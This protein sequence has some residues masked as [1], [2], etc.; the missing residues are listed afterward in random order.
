MT[1]SNHGW[2]VGDGGIILRD[3]AGSWG[4]ISSPTT[5]ALRSIFMLGDSDGWAVGDAGTAIR[6]QASNGQWIKVPTPTSARLNSV[7]LLDST[8]GWAVGAGGTIL[9]YD[10]IV[11]TGVADFVSTDLK[12][13]SQVN[14]REAWAVG[15][16]GTI[17][18]WTGTS[19]YP[20]TPSAPLSGNPDLQSIFL[21]PNGFGLIVGASP[22]P[23]GQ[24]TVIPIP[25]FTGSQ[26]LMVMAIIGVLVVLSLHQR[27]RKS[28]LTE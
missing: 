24:A 14:P 10:G 5:N 15:N 16:S 27:K 4:V 23:S 25:E 21:L 26:I 9:H 8:H 17:L 13:V 1:D 6:Y 19:W 3:S 18:H 7:N 12:S 20:E 28:P 22:S 11:W 2:A